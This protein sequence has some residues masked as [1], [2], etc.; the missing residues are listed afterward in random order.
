L[1]RWGNPSMWRSLAIVVGTWAAT[2]S[3]TFALDKI[4]ATIAAFSMPHLASDKYYND[5]ADALR[6]AP[7]TPF[8]V[9][10]LVRGELGA[11]ENIFYALRRERVQL[12]GVGYASIATAIPEFS[13]LNAPFLFATWEEVDFVYDNYL[14]PLLNEL[15]REHGLIGLRHYG[16]V[17]HGVYGKQP[18]NEPADL[19]N[20]RFRALI[21]PASQL[22]AEQL[23]ADMIQIP[24]TDIVTGLQTGLIDGGETNDLIFLM[25]G[26]S[27]N[28]PDYTFTR[29]TTSIL[30]ILV[31]AKWWAILTPTQQQLVDAGYPPAA[32][33][34]VG[35]RADS[36]REMAASVA[37]G[38]VRGHD[39]STEARARWVAATAP[40]HEKLVARAG[41]RAAELYRLVQAGKRAYAERNPSQEQQP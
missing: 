16:Q 4:P 12:V 41:G 20:V 5:W 30:A 29:H 40:V 2:I 27:R 28:A 37:N 26:T 15:L 36:V 9:K 23:Q 6:A 11:D 38:A 25:T 33:A 10:A 39:L 17:W 19:K 13:V 8:D 31:S 22:I 24:L 3:P 14:I 21:D 7:G 32:I 35:I 18:L 34:R 1:A